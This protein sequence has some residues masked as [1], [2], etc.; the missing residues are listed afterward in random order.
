MSFADKIGAVFSRKRLAILAGIVL[1]YCFWIYGLSTNPL[2]FYVDESCIAY[3]GYSIATTGAQEDGKFFP[4][5]I[6]CYTQGYSQYMSAAQPYELALLYLFVLPSVLSARI[7]AAT[8]VFLA[9]LLLGLLAARI[10]GQTWVGV[11]VAFSGLTTPWLFDFSRLVM[12]L[13]FFTFSVVLFLFCLYNAYR[14]GKWTFADAFFIAVADFRKLLLAHV[15]FAK[16][17]VEIV[18]RF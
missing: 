12:E 4:L 15:L 3:N 16:R 18:N 2:G 10:S 8:T 14:R 13:F 1:L 17:H 6:H 5:Y 11:I 7:C 9:I